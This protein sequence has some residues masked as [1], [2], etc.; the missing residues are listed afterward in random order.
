VKDRRDQRQQSDDVV[1]VDQVMARL[2]ERTELERPEDW[3]RSINEKPAH[4]PRHHH[5]REREIEQDLPE[6]AGARPVSKP[7]EA[8]EKRL[9][10]ELE[11]TAEADRCPDGEEPV[12]VE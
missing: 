1:D 7:T 3:L 9:D 8:R 4:E 2:W 12:D 10:P 5:G 11:V 6:R